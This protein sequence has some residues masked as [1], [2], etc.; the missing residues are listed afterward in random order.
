MSQ[1]DDLKAI[2]DFF[3]RT[4]ARNANAEQSK[5]NWIRWYSNL[6]TVDRNFN[7]AVLADAINRR[8]SFNALNGSP[9]DPT[10]SERSVTPEEREF[11]TN[12][13]TVN[14][15]G[16]TADAAQKAAWTK[17]TSVV[18]VIKSAVKGATPNATVSL[19][20]QKPTL[21]QGSTGNAVVEWQA[22]IGV[23]P[24]GKFGPATTAATKV[25]QKNR[26]LVPDGVVGIA[27]WT[28][29]YGAV[30]P[31]TIPVTQTA[32]TVVTSPSTIKPKT[33]EKPIGG[34]PNSRGPVSPSLLLPSVLSP[35]VVGMAGNIGK[36]LAIGLAGLAGI[37]GLGYIFTK[38]RR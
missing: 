12:Y 35:Q 3:L 30:P 8:T 21:R 29:A 2:N 22:I 16:M 25:W 17:S 1:S 5:S 37:L 34:D 14:V 19:P 23:K 15:T 9:E 6:G 32:K 38:P 4:P 24:D 27:S 11:F 7:S 13:P 26:A 36:G 28:A 31:K 20:S 10:T 33:E 18:D